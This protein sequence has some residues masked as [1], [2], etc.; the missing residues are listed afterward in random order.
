L[1][2][3]RTTDEAVSATIGILG[4]I[5]SNILAVIWGYRRVRNGPAVVFLGTR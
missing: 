2:Y 5:L 4:K 1:Q 3:A